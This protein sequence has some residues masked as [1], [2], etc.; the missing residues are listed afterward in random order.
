MRKFPRA[1]IFTK[2]TRQSITDMGLTEYDCPAA[3][4]VY[5]S[6]KEGSGIE[7][8]IGRAHRGRDVH[9]GGTPDAPKL[10]ID[11]ILHPRASFKAQLEKSKK[12]SVPF[13]PS[14]MKLIQ[15]IR[16]QVFEVNANN[17]MLSLL[18]TDIGEANLMC[19]NALERTEDNNDSLGRFTVFV[20]SRPF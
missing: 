16:D 5:F 1:Q 6:G 14:D 9:W 15:L 11:G 7:I 3:G 8:M 20:I 10:K 12:E 13:T 18:E 19:F 17:L 2:S 4:F